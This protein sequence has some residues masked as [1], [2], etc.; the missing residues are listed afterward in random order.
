MGSIEAFATPQAPNILVYNGD[1]I[2]V[3]L[4]VLPDEFY[5]IDTVTVDSSNN[6][7]INHILNVNLFGDKKGYFTTACWAGFRSAWEIVEN[8]L[9]LTGIYSCC[10][11]QDSLKADLTSLFKEKAINGKVKADWINSDVTVKGGKELTFFY[12][13]I[14]VFKKEIEFVFQAGKLINIQTFDNSKSRESAFHQNQNKMISFIYSNIDWDN[15]PAQQMPLRVIAKFSANED[16]KIDEVEV[17]RKSDHEIF[18]QEAVRVIKL[19]PD[20]DVLL[21]RGQLYRHSFFMPITFS[22]ENREKYGK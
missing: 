4:N 9:Y 15:L 13:E 7:Y 3:F 11:N 17:M 16:G 18:N 10:Y 21:I 12:N 8:Q 20:W 19:I 2:F 22:K 14:P 5:K 6:K 1:T